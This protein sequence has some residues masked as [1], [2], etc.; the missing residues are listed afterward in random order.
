MKKIEKQ[1]ID[2]P[3]NEL[4]CYLK[5]MSAVGREDTVLKMYQDAPVLNTARSISSIEEIFIQG[6]DRDVRQKVIKFL[7]HRYHSNV[8]RLPLQFSKGSNEKA[9][10]YHRIERTLI[11]CVSAD[12]SVHL[13]D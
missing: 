8:G 9:P 1:I 11:V 6:F 13:C 12:F 2:A 3:R 5:S 10:P 4:N 7:A